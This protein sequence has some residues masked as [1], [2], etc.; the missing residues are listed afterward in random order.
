M[1]NDANTCTVDQLEELNRFCREII[2]KDEENASA[3]YFLGIML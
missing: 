1:L 3:Y 2:A